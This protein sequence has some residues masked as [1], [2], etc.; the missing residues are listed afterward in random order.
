MNEIGQKLKE[1]RKRKGLSQEELANRANVNLRT[2]QRIENDESAP[3][4]NTLELLCRV[5]EVNIEDIID[6]GKEPD[7]KFLTYFHLS[8]LAVLFIP[9][10]NIL[11][12][13]ILWINKKD[14]ITD[15]QKVGASLLNFQIS[16]S[17]ISYITLII[18]AAS[19]ILHYQTA[20]Y[21]LISVFGIYA[22]NLFFPLY[23]AIS[24]HKG[25][26]RMYPKII[27]FIN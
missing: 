14:K 21:L 25:N 1:L 7:T 12:P 13:F 23:F 2:I 3:R 17:I 27:R 8:V 18:W 4:G 9:L 11:I 10:G 5:L 20:N 6:Y 24:N 15:L 19:K 22:L 26:I 16:W